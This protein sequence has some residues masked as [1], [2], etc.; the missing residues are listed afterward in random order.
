M[1]WSFA[2][3]EVA[4]TIGSRG[5]KEDEGRENR[6]GSMFLADAR[7]VRDES[8]GGVDEGALR[9]AMLN[10]MGRYRGMRHD[11]GCRETDSRA[12]VRLRGM[13][14]NTSVV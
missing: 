8:A 11:N 5:S 4:R 2:R 10:E 1:G 7:I 3:S 14:E 6:R 9:V 12:E 13:R